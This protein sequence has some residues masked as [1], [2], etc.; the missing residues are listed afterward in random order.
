MHYTGAV[1]FA[2]ASA[3]IL[4]IGGPA[5]AF[6]LT[7]SAFANGAPIPVRHTCDDANLSP[8]LAWTAPPSGTKRLALV[9]E[10]PD[11][12]AGTWAHWVVYDL[13]AGTRMLSEG[14]PP[15]KT[16]AG[17]GRQGTNDF[18]KIGWG[19]PCPPPGAAHRYYFKLFALD[20][21]TGL[22]PGATR[23]QVLRAIEGHTLGTAELMGTYRR[24]R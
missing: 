23:A 3:V 24:A 15:Q 22:D 18:K 9:C 1:R 14:V 13:P 8:A 10:D 4:A 17:G 21:E 5:M 20:A 7:S 16:L 19:G 6:E 11:A 12:P 2:L